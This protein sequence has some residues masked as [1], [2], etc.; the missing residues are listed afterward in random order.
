VMSV[1]KP[2]ILMDKNLCSQKKTNLKKFIQY[3]VVKIS[4]AKWIVVNT[5]LIVLKRR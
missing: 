3:C 1:P 2:T 4:R 5:T